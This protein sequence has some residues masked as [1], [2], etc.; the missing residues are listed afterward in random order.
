MFSSDS[1]SVANSSVCNFQKIGLWKFPQNLCQ[2]VRYE[3]LPFA[4]RKTGAWFQTFAALSMRSAL[5]WDVTQCRMVICDR[6]FGTI[7]WSHFQG[8]YNSWTTWQLI[9]EP[10]GFTETSVTAILRC[11]KS[12]EGR[13]LENRNFKLWFLCNS[14]QEWWRQ[15]GQGTWLF[16]ICISKIKMSETW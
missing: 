8:L 2:C 16:A 13:S 10:R 1:K 9:L 6:C 14:C 3:V 7:Y 15:V 4:Q 5:F 12:Q 11:V